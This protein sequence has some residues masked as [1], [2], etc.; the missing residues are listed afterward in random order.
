MSSQ[1]TA[2]ELSML[3]KYDAE[4]LIGQV[5]YQQ[6]A[7]IFNYQNGYDD[8]I[9]LSSQTQSSASKD[10]RYTCVYV[11]KVIVTGCRTLIHM[12]MYHIVFFVQKSVR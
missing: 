1:E 12:Y 11:V 7:D 10:E 8:S 5:S 9:K 2:F 3:E 6:K 4:L